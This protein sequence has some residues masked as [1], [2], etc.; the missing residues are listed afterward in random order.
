MTRHNIAHAS[1]AASTVHN[2]FSH[3]TYAM[4]SIWIWLRRYAHMINFHQLHSVRAR[5]SHFCFE[6]IIFQFSTQTTDT[7]KPTVAASNNRCVH[8][9][10]CSVQTQTM[11]EDREKHAL[12]RIIIKSKA[13]KCVTKWLICIF[14]LAADAI[15][16]FRGCC[17]LFLFCFYAHSASMHHVAI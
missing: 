4:P 9:D 7:S 1:C 12:I 8:S 16:F 17:W 13:W 10:L 5:A 6:L 14:V 2:D 15:H 3:R 11:P